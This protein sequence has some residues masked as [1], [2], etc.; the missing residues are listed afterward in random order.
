MG[1]PKFIDE[2]QNEADQ[3]TDDNACGKRKVERKMFT[4]DEDVSRELSQER[5]FLNAQHH[6]ADHDQDGSE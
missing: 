6:E 5:Q 2:E 3:N 4:L 1:L